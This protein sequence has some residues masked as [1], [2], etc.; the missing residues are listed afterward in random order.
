MRIIFSVIIAALAAVAIA[1]VREIKHTDDGGVIKLFLTDNLWI[2]GAKAAD[3][4][5]CDTACSGVVCLYG[6]KPEDNTKK[7]CTDTAG[8]RACICMGD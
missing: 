3:T 4:V 2:A 5:S 6:Y 1:Q 8:E 7:E